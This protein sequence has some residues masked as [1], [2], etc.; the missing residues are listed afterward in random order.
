[1]ALFFDQ[2][3]N[4][5]QRRPGPSVLLAPSEFTPG[6]DYVF[7]ASPTTL[8]PHS[9]IQSL[10][11]AR[12][13]P[14]QSFTSGISR[15]ASGL[16][17]SLPSRRRTNGLVVTPADISASSSGYV[18]PKSQDEFIDVAGPRI[19]GRSENRESGVS[20]AGEAEV[21]RRNWVI[22]RV[23]RDSRFQLFLRAETDYSVSLIAT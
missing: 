2:V 22:F 6:S 14:R 12:L 4:P 1:M 18:T 5:P 15:A 17:R 19:G 11:A 10:P 20:L 3:T 8:T 16:K 13:K 21:Y 9:E 23:P 7:V